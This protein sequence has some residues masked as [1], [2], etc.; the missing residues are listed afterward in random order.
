MQAKAIHRHNKINCM[1]CEGF[2]SVTQA[3]HSTIMRAGERLTL[4]HGFHDCDRSFHQHE[5]RH[6]IPSHVMLMRLHIK[7]FR[8]DCLA[9][10]PGSVIR[11]R[12]ATVGERACKNK[13]R[14]Q[15]AHTLVLCISDTCLRLHRPTV[16]PDPR[17]CRFAT[18]AI[19][20]KKTPFA[21]RPQK[22][23]PPVVTESPQDVGEDENT[24]QRCWRKAQREELAWRKAQ[25]VK[26]P[27]T[28]GRLLARP[29]RSP[30]PSTGL[31]KTSTLA[32]PLPTGSSQQWIQHR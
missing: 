6:G 10:Q 1:S 4:N 3:E 7:D 12:V 30:P 32:S 26:V 18:N 21:R 24:S 2:T 16:T 19:V 11:K 29:L 9:R 15:T 27:S 22:S 28:W 14:L 5:K 13:S 20:K 8:D 23:C 31:S 17:D 25:A